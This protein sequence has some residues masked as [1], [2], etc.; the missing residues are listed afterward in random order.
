MKEQLKQQLIDNAENI[1]QIVSKGNT[2][3][4]K[5]NKDGIVIYE[6]TRKKQNNKE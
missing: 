3:E 4:I 1:I 6:V 5:K 2:A